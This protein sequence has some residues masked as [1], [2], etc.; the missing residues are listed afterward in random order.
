MD[1]RAAAVS[2]AD[3]YTDTSII[4]NGRILVE[5]LEPMAAGDTDQPQEESCPR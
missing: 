3:R 1:L 4:L 2:G 5:C